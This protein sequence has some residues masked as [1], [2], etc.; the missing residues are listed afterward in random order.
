MTLSIYLKF[1]FEINKSCNVIAKEMTNAF[2]NKF[3][4][5]E[6]MYG[7]VCTGVTV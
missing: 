1:I 6:N 7:W 5:F 2:M 3:E 4:L